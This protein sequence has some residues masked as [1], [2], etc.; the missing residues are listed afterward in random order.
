MNIMVHQGPKVPYGALI[1]AHACRTMGWGA[2]RPTG[3][4]R[5]AEAPAPQGGHDDS[6]RQS[7]C[8]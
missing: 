7:I 8:R 6:V 4:P 2:L 3:P 1:L 5:G